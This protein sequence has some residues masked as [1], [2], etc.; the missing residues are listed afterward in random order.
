M[1][2]ARCAIAVMAKA[3][4]AG[5]SKTRLSPP[6]TPEEAAALSA[7]FLRDSTENIRLAARTASIAG[8]V[9]YAPD[10]AAHLF[11][12]HLAA[13]TGLVLA[14][15]TA[16]D[17]AGITGIGC[18]LLHA[19]TSLLA[20][21][22]ESVC[23]L[24]ADSPN[25]PTQFLIDAAEAL[26]P[27]GD[28]MVL[29]VA[30]D[31]GYYLIGLKRPHVAVFRDIAWSS[32]QVSRQTLQ[33]AEEAG[34]EAVLLPKWF[35]VDDPASLHRLADDLTD[36]ADGPYAAPAARAWLSVN[37]AALADDSARHSAKIGRSP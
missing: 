24:N 2:R 10:G 37:R 35:D 22:H 21:G 6:L 9:A 33:R 7:A 29:G 19:L 13:G 23:L 18:S 26:A 12:D 8:Y 30:D 31:G 27:P 14:D 15:G 28:R 1:P 36:A 32:E 5:Q 3:P 11:D 20:S 16:I 4:Q 17:V 34:L 25:L